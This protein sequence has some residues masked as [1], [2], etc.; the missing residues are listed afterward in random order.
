MKI[1]FEFISTEDKIRKLHLCYVSNNLLL[2][3]SIIFAIDKIIVSNNVVLI[4][5][6]TVVCLDCLYV[7][8][9]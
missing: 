3:V 9:S 1:S 7:V 4:H 6:Y 5:F 8:P 2:K